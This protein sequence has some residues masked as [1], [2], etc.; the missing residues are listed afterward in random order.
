MAGAVDD[1]TINIVLVII[2]PIII[3]IIGPATEKAQRPNV[4]RRCRGIV[5][6]L[7]LADLH[8]KRWQVETTDVRVQ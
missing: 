3:I 4:L 1:N 2:R 5:N 8:V 7:R 6:W